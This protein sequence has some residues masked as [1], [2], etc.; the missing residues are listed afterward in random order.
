MKLKVISALGVASLAFA[1]SACGGAATTNTN[2]ANK[3]ANAAN[4]VAN[5][6]GNATNTVA[7][8][9][10]PNSASNA[11]SMASTGGDMITIESAGIQ[12]ASPKGFKIEK[13]GET[14]NLIS[15]DDAFEVY[16]H[17]PKDGDYNKAI[18]EVGTEIDDYLKDVKV[19]GNGVKGSFGGMDA[20]MFDGTGVDKEDNKPVSWELIVL[21][22]PKKPV[23]IVSYGDSATNTK[24]SKEIDEIAKSIKK[25]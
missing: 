16:F 23:L 13:D 6:A 5:T 4:S 24:Y 1:F 12:V 15:P 21:N 11:N 18:D 22:A 20:T 10:A 8:A 17:V 2:L 14:T 9:V 7:N 3:T 25:Q 19:T